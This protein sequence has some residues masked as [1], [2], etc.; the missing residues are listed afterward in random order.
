LKVWYGTDSAKKLE[1]PDVKRDILSHFIILSGESFGDIKTRYIKPGGL[2]NLFRPPPMD[3][4]GKLSVIGGSMAKSN[5]A[6]Y[7]QL[8][9][10]P[11]DTDILTS[12]NKLCSPQYADST[13]VQTYGKDGRG[14]DCFTELVGGRTGIWTQNP[15]QM[16]YLKA[17]NFLLNN[18]LIGRDVSTNI[19]L[20]TG[21]SN[22]CI[23][24]QYPPKNRE[25]LLAKIDRVSDD[26]VSAKEQIQ[27]IL[28]EVIIFYNFGLEPNVMP[29]KR[30]V[31]TYNDPSHPPAYFE[32]IDLSTV[33][34]V[35]SSKRPAESISEMSDMSEMSE[36]R[37]TGDGSRRLRVKMNEGNW[38]GRRRTKK[39]RAKKNNRSKNNRNN[40]SMK[41]RRPIKS[42]RR[43]RRRSRRN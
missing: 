22:P 9:G 5:K 27:G 32:V 6:H 3:G 36:T 8:L 18:G 7:S 37:E 2:F 21:G 41:R 25:I 16:N 14:L 40:N 28:G 12:I 13:G 29:R 20:G 24:V 19:V 1:N 11:Y 33:G 17:I 34:H 38:G 4:I 26:R 15:T 10:A 23:T 31:G 30:P 42:G 39:S 35:P 43:R